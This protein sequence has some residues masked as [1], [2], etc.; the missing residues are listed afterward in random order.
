M[1]N[2]NTSNKDKDKYKTDIKNMITI[3]RTK[4]IYENINEI[5]DIKDSFLFFK[6]TPE[7]INNSF[8]LPD[9]TDFILYIY[10]TQNDIIE[11]IIGDTTIITQKLIAN[12]YF[13]LKTNVIP[14][15]SL[16]YSRQNKINILTENHGN[17]HLV[18]CN[19]YSKLRE[20]LRNNI[21]ISTVFDGEKESKIIYS[22]GKLSK[23]NVEIK[24]FITQ[25]RDFEDVIEIPNF[26]VCSEEYRKYLANKVSKDI[27]YE[28]LEIT[29]NPDR[30]RSFLSIDEIQK[31]LN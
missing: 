24:N 8:E 13:I 14:M 22:R 9:Q 21:S 27:Y 30:I 16:Y 7:I 26:Y 4:H 12:E 31:Y 3:S 25:W 28:L 11:I 23:D 5:V 20:F 6:H 29:L 18:C 1:G 10:S 19:V 15:C 17:I 2:I